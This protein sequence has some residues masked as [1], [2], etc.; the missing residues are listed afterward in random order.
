MSLYKRQVT[1]TKD[2]TTL[3]GTFQ[4]CHEGGLKYCALRLSVNIAHKYV[5][6]CLCSTWLPI[7]VKP[8]AM[9]V[10]NSPR[11]K[12]PNVQLLCLPSVI[13]SAHLSRRPFPSL[14]ALSCFD[15]V[16]A[17]PDPRPLGCRLSS[18]RRSYPT[19]P[20]WRGLGAEEGRRERAIAALQ[21]QGVARRRVHEGRTSCRDTRVPAATLDLS[22]DEAARACG[23][24]PPDLLASSSKVRPRQNT[25][26]P[27]SP[28]AQRS[29]GQRSTPSRSS[30][31]KPPGVLLCE[32]AQAPA[33]SP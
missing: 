5:A 20:V 27:A 13:T 30:T 14:S 22:E 15:L 21:H 28:S 1:V 2:N 29:R 6:T 7:N 24:I 33:S 26:L 3:A 19:C 12:R 23:G 25:L 16:V 9:F 32:A 11:A 10:H 17:R 18:L 8:L 31:L 4:K